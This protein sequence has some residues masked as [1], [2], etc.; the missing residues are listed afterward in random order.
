MQHQAVQG[1]GAEDRVFEEG[2]SLSVDYAA[3]A[4]T[5]AQRL[6]H[7]NSEYFF[8]IQFT[9][10]VPNGSQGCASK[11]FAIVIR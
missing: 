2:V 8:R 4:Q 5:L 10:S 1:A 3:A 9:T 6:R 7:Q 11:E